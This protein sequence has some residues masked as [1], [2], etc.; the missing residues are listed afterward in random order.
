MAN[1]KLQLAVDY[2]YFSSNRSINQLEKLKIIHMFMT[3]VKLL[4]P[5]KWQKLDFCHNFM[6]KT[7]VMLNLVHETLMSVNRRA[8]NAS[9]E[10]HVPLMTHHTFSTIPVQQTGKTR[11]V[12]VGLA[13]E[14]D[15]LQKMFYR[16]A[17]FEVQTLTLLNTFHKECIFYIPTVETLHPFSILLE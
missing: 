14:G 5:Q 3:N 12:G 7:N 17:L 15:V 10:T 16:E 11:G 8:L 9:A 1:G 13:R 6:G 2:L 4:F